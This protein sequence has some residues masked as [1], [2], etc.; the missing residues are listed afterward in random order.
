MLFRLTNR[1]NGY[2]LIELI[3]VTALSVLLLSLSVTAFYRLKKPSDLESAASSFRAA[4]SQ[5]RSLS[6]TKLTPC[7][8]IVD[9]NPGGDKISVERRTISAPY[10]WIK[11][12][13]TNTLENVYVA[14]P[15]DSA[16]NK[17]N[18][19]AESVYFRTDGSCCLDEDAISLPD[20]N[21]KINIDFVLI[22][23]RQNEEGRIRTVSFDPHS[24]LSRLLERSYRD[25]R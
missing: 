15:G 21:D 3:T 5:A 12:S 13:V 4:A 19:T 6:V 20:L 1:A 23:S 25:G 9:R 22:V 2:T 24:G 11:A 7:R 10:R 18:G 16:K 17:K 8:V 14:F